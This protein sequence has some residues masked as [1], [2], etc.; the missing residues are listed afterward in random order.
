MCY[1]YVQWKK[2]RLLLILK[3]CPSF[4]ISICI[5]PELVPENDVFVSISKLKWNS[6]FADIIMEAVQELN[7]DVDDIN[8]QLN[9]RK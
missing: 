8:L 2:E 6:Y 9:T 7:H 1:I 4:T 5:F 3:I